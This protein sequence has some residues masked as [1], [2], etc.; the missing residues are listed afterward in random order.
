M[1]DINTGLL[2]EKELPPAL[3]KRRSRG[4]FLVSD[5]MKSFKKRPKRNQRFHCREWQRMVFYHIPIF[6]GFLSFWFLGLESYS[7][8][9]TASYSFEGIVTAAKTTAMHYVTKPW[10]QWYGCYSKK[11]ST[12]KGLKVSFWGLFKTNFYYHFRKLFLFTK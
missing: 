4:G 6:L 8:R 11:S 1:Y 5:M 9:A 7:G 12:W 10:R 2:V 3:L